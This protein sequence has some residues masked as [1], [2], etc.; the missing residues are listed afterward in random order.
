MSEKGD[1]TAG[2]GKRCYVY[3]HITGFCIAC[4]GRPQPVVEAKLPKALL[5]QHCQRQGWPPP[6]F[7]RCAAGGLRLP[8]AGIRYSVTLARLHTLKLKHL[9]LAAALASATRSPWCAFTL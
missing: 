8:A 9:C 3:G 2:G 6:R 5:Q 1:S 4:A 7:E